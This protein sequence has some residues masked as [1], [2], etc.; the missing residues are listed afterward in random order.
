MIGL[1]FAAAITF[2]MRPGTAAT[3]ADAHTLP[4]ES[5]TDAL[6]SEASAPADQAPVS[7]QPAVAL[8]AHADAPATPPPAGASRTD[9]AV[10]PSVEAS[11]VDTA[12][13]AST[14]ATSVAVQSDNGF[15]TRA[16]ANTDDAS[17]APQV[18]ST[19][20][21]TAS[22]IVDEPFSTDAATRD[23]DAGRVAPPPSPKHSQPRSAVREPPPAAIDALQPWWQS[24]A[25]RGFSVQYVGQASHADAMVI[26]FSKSLADAGAAAQH[27]R[28][29][30][31]K[32]VSANGLWSVGR[33]PYVL[34][35][36]G[37]TPGRYTVH[38]DPAL[39]SEGGKPLGV[40]LQ[41][42]VYIQ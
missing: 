22:A 42:P 16:F 2:M 24:P 6:V 14:S 20:E 40:A 18:A 28:V 41:G 34:V 3:S 30:D 15:A 29:L 35:Y 32:G 1:V 38:I 26:R 12:V 37:V 9:T 31:E 25:A 8:V 11:S 19:A 17:V 27:I 7:Q 33:N 36:Q 23:A 5:G 10:M 13:D 4:A 39:S 21:P